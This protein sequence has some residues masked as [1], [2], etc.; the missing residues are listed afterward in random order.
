[1]STVL[2]SVFDLLVFLLEGCISQPMSLN[3]LSLETSN[4]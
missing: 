1:M 3:H 4:S 2:I